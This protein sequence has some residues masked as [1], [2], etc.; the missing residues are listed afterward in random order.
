MDLA[1]QLNKYVDHYRDSRGLLPFALDLKY[2]HSLRVA[3]NA[4]LIAREIGLAP[5][6]IQLAHLC[7]LLHDV[8][9]FSQYKQYGSFHDADTIDHGLAGRQVLEASDASSHFPPDEWAAILCTVEY[10]NKKT[11]DLPGNISSQSECL[12]RII[13]DADKLDIMDLVLQSVARDGFRELPEMLPHIQQS[14]EVTPAVLEEFQKSKMI[15]ICSLT[16][17]TDFLLM[18]ATWFYDF[19]YSA[20][21]QMAQQRDFLGRLAIETPDIPVVRQ[22]FAC[23]KKD[24]EQG[25]NENV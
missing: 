22:L 21:R 19:N 17:T 5:K 10:H 7:G 20:S 15:S 6:D 24:L 12:L 9:R 14:R 23:I 18:L 13:R 8:G 25:D 3:K 2:S 1:D 4:Q 11:A 16:T